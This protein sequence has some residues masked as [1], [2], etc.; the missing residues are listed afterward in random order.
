VPTFTAPKHPPVDPVTRKTWIIS[1]LDAMEMDR[2]IYK[3]KETKEYKSD[4]I[5]SKSFVDAARTIEKTF[6]MHPY[7]HYNETM[8]LVVSLIRMIHRKIVSIPTLEREKNK[9]RKNEGRKTTATPLEL[10][11]EASSEGDHNGD[12]LWVHRLAS[13]LCR[14]T[15]NDLRQ[16][17]S[18]ETYWEAVIH[19]QWNKERD[20]LHQEITLDEEEDEENVKSDETQPREEDIHA[21]ENARPQKRHRTKWTCQCGSDKLITSTHQKRKADEGATVYV[22]CRS[23]GRMWSKNS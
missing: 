2:D 20:I 1:I 3:Q 16:L 18:N 21:K 8:Q 19:K 23:C 15:S 10:H 4:R 6:Y 14:V 12:N 5:A 11:A 13:L 22:R 9:K 7:G 17:V